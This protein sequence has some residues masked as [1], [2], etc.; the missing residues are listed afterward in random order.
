MSA[1]L[2]GGSI[3]ILWDEDDSA[4]VTITGGVASFTVGG[5]PV[6]F[7]YTLT[8]STTFTTTHS[9]VYTVSVQHYGYEVANT[10]D[11]TREVTLRFGEEEIFAPTPD[12]RAT[13]SG[14]GAM[15][16]D[17]VSTD[18][19]DTTSD[20]GVAF[21]TAIS[22]AKGI[23]R[24]DPTKKYRVITGTLRSDVAGTWYALDDTAHTP[25]GIDSVTV[26]GSG[27]LEVNY[28]SLG[29][30]VVVFGSAFPDETLTASG[31]SIGA[32]VATN[33]ATLKIYRDFPVQSGYVYYDTGTATW[34]RTSPSPFSS[35]FTYSNATGKLIITHDTL[36]SEMALDVAAV[37]RAGPYVVMID[38]TTTSTVSLFF[39]DAATGAVVTGAPTANH[40]V[41]VRHGG[42]QR[43]LV[44]ATDIT[45]A[46]YPSSNIWFYAVVEVP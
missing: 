37:A 3:R 36:P 38:S 8:S 30:N 14:L 40:R 46:L 42:G 28:A 19:V 11:G 34:K 2:T 41:Y 31:F 12:S 16:R 33:M 35:T 17:I 9:G 23:P 25:Y 13:G 44:N 10:P 6:T 39:Y 43:L 20:I 4:D 29:G 21:G 26:N 24:L 7:P 45:T 27:H 32:S 22:A 18:V 1:T 5:S 15:V